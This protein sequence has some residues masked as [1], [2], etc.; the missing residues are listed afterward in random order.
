MTP[1]FVAVVNSLVFWPIALRVLQ[2][3]TI[4]HAIF[5]MQVSLFLTPLIVFGLN[6]TFL[7][8]RFG[9]EDEAESHLDVQITQFYG[10]IS[11]LLLFLAVILD[12]EPLL[13][14]SMSFG[15][16]SGILL[17]ALCRGRSWFNKFALSSFALQLVVPFAALFIATKTNPE[18][19]IATIALLTLVAMFSI[20][21]PICKLVK[22][23]HQ[24]F[25]LLLKSSRSATLFL[26]GSMILLYGNKV[27]LGLFYTPEDVAHFQIPAVVA[28]GL[29][30]AYT[31]VSP[32]LFD[33]V[34]TLEK[35]LWQ[36]EFQRRVK[37]IEKY[38]GFTI[39]IPFPVGILTYFLSPSTFP[40]SDLI[41]ASLII[42]MS[43][44]IQ[45][46]TD[47]LVH[48]TIKNG[49]RKALSLSLLPVL[50]TAFVSV[51]YLNLDPMI[52]VSIATTSGFALRLLTLEFC[53]YREVRVVKF[54]KL[55]WE[56][57]GILL[58]WAIMINLYRTIFS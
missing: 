29:L 46:L 32:M 20:T 58:S 35:G 33:K 8:T 47:V 6:Y 7:T 30:I 19:F 45:V 26:F 31:S 9:S 12:F 15:Q 3:D 40:R 21:L 1:F 5:L 41:L 48:E 37:Q 43:F 44:P 55:R 2:T 16:A 14:V 42:S 54:S 52:G 4:G 38:L 39:L 36:V 24:S 25:A 57:G 11:F 50:P 51:N 22:F 53:K 28:G 10:M 13:L 23:S 56:L 49:N 17:L 18:K 34:L 27:Y